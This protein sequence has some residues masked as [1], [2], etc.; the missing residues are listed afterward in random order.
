MKLLAGY[1]GNEGLVRLPLGL[2]TLYGETKSVIREVK[3]MGHHEYIQPYRYCHK[4]ESENK[5]K[6]VNNIWIDVAC[7]GCGKPKPP[8]VRRNKIVNINNIN[9]TVNGCKVR[10]KRW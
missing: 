6:N 7:P 8:P 1:F 9:I 4:E 10:H 5:L 3:A 2:H